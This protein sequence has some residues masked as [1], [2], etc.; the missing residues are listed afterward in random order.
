MLCSMGGIYGGSN[1]HETSQRK[2]TYFEY[3]GG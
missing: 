3:K 1:E 2:K